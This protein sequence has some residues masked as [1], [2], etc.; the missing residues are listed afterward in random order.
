[1]LRPIRNMGVALDSNWYDALLW[2]ATNTPEP[3]RNP[4]EYYRPG[5]GPSAV[6]DYGVLAWW[7]YGYW[8]TRVARRVPVTNPRQSGMHDAAMF[9][10][11]SNEADANRIVE[12]L[13]VRYIAVD[14][15]LQATNTLSADAQRG[16]F[17]AIAL[18]AGRNPSDYCGLFS[19]DAVAQETPRTP[20]TYCF[21]EYYR[22]MAMRMYLH[23]GRAATPAGPVMV[24]SYR[25]E[26]RD[27]QLTNIVTGEW[28][29]ATYDEA[30][31]FVTASGR[32]D[33][34]I[35]SKRPHETCVPLEALSSY[36]PVFKASG[37]DGRGATA[38]RVVQLFEYRHAP[39]GQ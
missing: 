32:R 27:R 36:A 16:F 3:F 24:L 7:D 2:L 37:R 28:R 35:V 34:A 23:G 13:G 29:F 11:S 30:S 1:M 5:R 38:P 8:I 14:W 26:I 21:P 39:T 9:L 22:T 6:A 18:A 10:V 20:V 33:V 31:R 19:E 17:R 25:R 12:R 15:Q 4:T